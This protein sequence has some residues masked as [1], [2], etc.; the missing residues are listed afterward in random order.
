MTAMA[1]IIQAAVVC[2]G[3]ASCLG[4]VGLSAYAVIALSH[5]RPLFPWGPR[6]RVERAKAR[7]E[8][9]ELAIRE[10]SAEIRRLA[11]E[12]SRQAIMQAIQDGVPVVA[13]LL[14]AVEPEKNGAA[15]KMRADFYRFG[16][17]R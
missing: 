9:A 1:K 12:P 3:V 13:E 15:E 10:E 11:L 17:T 16:A 6:N 5:G 14:A 4:V 2:A 7:A 8:I